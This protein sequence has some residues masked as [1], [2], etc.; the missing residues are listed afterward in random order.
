[1]MSA[2]ATVSTK[3]RVPAIWLVP[4]VALLLGIWMAVHTALN[5][6]PEVS[7][8][9]ATAEGIEAGKTRI[10]ARSVEI[11]IVESVT[12]GEDL[13]SV[14]L[15]V[16]LDPVAKSLL[17]EDSRFWV[18]RPR[19]GTSGVSGLGTIVSGAYIEL[20][21][22]EGK[23]GRRDFKG[24]EDIPVTPVGE[25]GLRLTLISEEA[26]S[27]GAGTTV[28]FKDHA[29]GRVE[30]TE[31]DSDNQTFRHQVFIDA[32]YDVLV[33]DA[34]R[35]WNVS[36]IHVDAGVDGVKVNIGS[37]QSLLQGGVTFGVPEGLP[38]GAAVDN[39]TEFVL[40]GSYD[41]AAQKRYQYHTYYVVRFK[42]SL[43]GLLPGA[44]VLFRGINIGVVERI[45][46]DAL[47]A[48][49]GIAGQGSAIPVLIKLEA[50]RLGLGDTQVVTDQLIEAVKTGVGNGLRGTLATGNLLTG[51]KLISFDYY[52]NE[53]SASPGDF[54]GYTTIPT[55]ETG[56]ERIEV[57][58]SQ[59]LDKLNGLPVE[60]T[61]ESAN[62]TL[63]GLDGTVKELRELLASD[64]VQSMPQALTKTMSELTRTLESF[65]SGSEFY[66]DL[67]RALA[68]L[69][70]TLQGLD[71]LSTTLEKQPSLLI[72]PKTI[73]PDPE[74][75]VLP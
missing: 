62:R 72:F 27:I 63:A 56:L 3:R 15:V 11:G 55:I 31:F 38:A 34:T 23:E 67:A 5:K 24:L 16:Q 12:L 21:P 51:S 75:E 26:G 53:T 43:A 9:F 17:R 54:N 14:V 65:S 69:I 7:I 58:V 22:G 46:I 20:D 19:F 68:E 37:L 64:K 2:D 60:A 36:G 28:L 4:L 41:S 18:V 44:P 42:Q 73:R 30:S 59:L 40:Y 52:A 10:K 47:A 70:L 50:G 39:E 13:D 33:N 61:V 74:P 66:D 25:P 35:F 1:M 29:V 8:S 6:G 57:K 32:P 45:M 71:G 48:G 49:G